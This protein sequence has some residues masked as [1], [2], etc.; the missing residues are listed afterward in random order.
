M[1]FYEF[2]RLH[3]FKK[4]RVDFISGPQFSLAHKTHSRCYR[5]TELNHQADIPKQQGEA[6]PR[7]ESQK[8]RDSSQSIVSDECPGRERNWGWESVSQRRLCSKFHS[9]NSSRSACSNSHNEVGAVLYLLQ[10]SC[11][12]MRFLSDAGR[13]ETHQRQVCTWCRFVRLLSSLI[14]RSKQPQQVVA[15]G[16]VDPKICQVIDHSAVALLNVVCWSTKVDINIEYTIHQ[17]GSDFFEGS[18]IARIQST[19]DWHRS[20]LKGSRRL[21]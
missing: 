21:L 19:Y 15:P 1:Y 11:T 8:K 3:P 14:R 13:N 9:G 16:I 7:L 17:H 2:D 10:S 18:H 12:V 20:P 5:P 4:F 6:V